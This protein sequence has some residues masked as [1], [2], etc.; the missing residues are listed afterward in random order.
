ML[1][2]RSVTKKLIQ[3]LK[4]ELQGT[5]IVVGSIYVKR[6]EP[7]VREGFEKELQAITV[8]GDKSAFLDKQIKT[9]YNSQVKSALTA[10]VSDIMP[11]KCSILYTFSEESQ[12][13]DLDPIGTLSRKKMSLEYLAKKALVCPLSSKINKKIVN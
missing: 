7:V 11:V 6:E 8:F 13:F 1:R 9:F 5:D 12:A 10:I 2:T 3:E 4:S